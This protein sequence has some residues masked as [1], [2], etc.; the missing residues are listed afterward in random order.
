MIDDPESAFHAY[1]RAFETL[2]P[3][4]AL[5]FY[6]LPGM[7]IAPQGVFA[8]PDANTAR[9]LLSEFMGQLRSQSYRRTEVVGLTVRKLSLGLATCAGTFVRFNT[10]GEEIARLG[11]TYTL[12]NAGSWKIIVAVVHEPVAA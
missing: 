4:A 10:G 6:H 1:L 3:E 11:F 8:F 5:P 2:D 9:A 12:R 7:F